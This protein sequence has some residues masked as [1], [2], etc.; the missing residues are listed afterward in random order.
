METLLWVESN[1]WRREGVKE[2]P[3][4]GRKAPDRKLSS[5]PPSLPLLGSVQS[6]RLTS[7]SEMHLTGRSSSWRTRTDVPGA[8]GAERFPRINF[9]T[10]WLLFTPDQPLLWRWR[11]YFTCS[12]SCRCP[13][14]VGVSVIRSPAF[15][16]AREQP[17]DTGRSFNLAFGAAR[18]QKCF[19]C[20]DVPWCGPLN[21]DPHFSAGR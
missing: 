14:S 16:R 15:S 1:L 2:W 8:F 19:L 6:Q 11:L 9:G 3:G 7:R 18:H 13:G 10:Y 17:A 21:W 12:P 20:K 4:V 5:L